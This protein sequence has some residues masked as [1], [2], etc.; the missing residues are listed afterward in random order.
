MQTITV[1]IA[2]AGGLAFGY[3]TAA[4]F[5]SRA[6]ALLLE[7]FQEDKAE[8]IE[9]ADLT[10]RELRDELVTEKE[11]ETDA[12]VSAED[13]G[14]SRSKSKKKNKHKAKSKG[15][16]SNEVVMLQTAQEELR[17]QHRSELE[18][19]EV[20]SKTALKELSKTA[21]AQRADFT[22]ALA[23]LQ[24]DLDEALEAGN[25]APAGNA[26]FVKA[27]EGAGSD[28]NPILQAI[29][30][31]EAQNTSVLV[32]ANGI[33]VA[34]AGDSDTS[35]NISASAGYLMGIPG[36]LA[37]TLPLD[38]HYSFRLSDQ[39]NTI[40]GRTFDVGG[41]T[42]ALVTVGA[43]APADDSIGLAVNSLHKALE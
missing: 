16:V 14:K 23:G 17:L 9:K 7:Q 34:S 37:G 28:L 31:N 43:A 4:H 30:S 33:I 13:A 26:D 41:D 8:A 39:N 21:D 35:D 32:D 12:P 29:V 22:K 3:A 20:A 5:A 1:V 6:K 38:S 27:L 24:G 42:L 10:I 36:Q 25:A 11:R 2:S 18:Q 15:T 40:M 19:Q